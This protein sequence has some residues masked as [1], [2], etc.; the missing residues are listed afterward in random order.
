[1][2]GSIEASTGN[3][4]VP[5]P[6]ERPDGPN[7][8][9]TR[10]YESFH[11]DDTL[12]FQITWTKLDSQDIVAPGQMRVHTYFNI[13]ENGDIRKVSWYDDGTSIVKFYNKGWDR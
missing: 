10:G 8:V 7:F 13:Y 11:Q 4:K 3:F 5:Y 1:M 12:R 2:I 9:G 6:K